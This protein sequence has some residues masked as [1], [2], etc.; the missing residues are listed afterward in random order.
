MADE[1]LLFQIEANFVNYL[2]L[3]ENYFFNSASLNKEAI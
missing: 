2:I 1:L 3:V